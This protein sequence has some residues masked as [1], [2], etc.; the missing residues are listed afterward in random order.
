[1]PTGMDAAIP[2]WPDRIFQ[3][4][5]REVSMG[6]EAKSTEGRLTCPFTLTPQQIS[7]EMLSKNQFSKTKAKGYLTSTQLP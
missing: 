6:K 3:A 4:L 1:M 5:N 7:M 2:L